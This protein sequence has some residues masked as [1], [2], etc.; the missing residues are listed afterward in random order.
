MISKNNKI[1]IVHFSSNIGGIE[2]MLPGI[3][4][5]MNDFTFSVFLIRPS[6]SA[7]SNIYKNCNIPI[8]FGSDRNLVAAYKLIKY[9]RQYRNEIF[10]VFNIGPVFFLCLK[11][12]GVKNIVYSIHGTKYWKTKWHKSILRILWRLAISK[13]VLMTSNTIFSGTTFTKDVIPEIRIKLLYNP[14]D[15]NRFQ[16]NN[17]YER[18]SIPRKII[19]CGRLVKGK[20]L[21][22]WIDLAQFLIPHFP[23]AVFEIY[24]EGPKKEELS[25]KIFELGLNE[26][27][28]LKGKTMEPEKIYQ[29]ADVLLF[30]SEYESF[31]NVV[32][33][34]ILCGTPVIAGAIPS[35]ME[36]FSDF[37]E[38]LVQLDEN[39]TFNVLDKLKKLE[40]LNKLVIKAREDFTERFGARKHYEELKE[41]YYSFGNKD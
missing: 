1:N 2:V 6:L 12:A 32:V 18:I 9:A 3:I 11:F 27:I 29:N 37:P 28:F 13:N 17:K 25:E 34:S 4:S 5:S 19:Y 10:H 40:K 8:V 38:F 36:I 20:N 30:I 21:N 23:D 15:N 39:L 33:E 16:Q 31:G 14:V 26:K 41:I 35:M 22:L 7:D 24:G